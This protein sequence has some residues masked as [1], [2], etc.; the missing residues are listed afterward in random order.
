[1]AILTNTEH[2]GRVI[3]ELMDQWIEPI[4]GVDPL[5]TKT[6]PILDIEI[7]PRPYVGT[8]RDIAAKHEVLEKDGGLAMRPEQRGAAAFTFVN[9][10]QDGRME[11][12]AVGGRLYRRTE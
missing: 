12:L 2:G 4:F 1:V 7:D 8:H 3:N 10:M 5:P 9:P 11:H 6:H